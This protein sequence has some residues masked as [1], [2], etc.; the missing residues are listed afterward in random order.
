MQLGQRL[1]PTGIG[2]AQKGQS[3]VAAAAAGGGPCIRAI[4]R[5]MRKMQRAM[6]RKVTI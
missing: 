2:V 4:M 6:I 5:M 1:A 3:L